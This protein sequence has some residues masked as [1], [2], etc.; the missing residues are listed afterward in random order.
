VT[1]NSSA[2]KIRVRSLLDERRIR[3]QYRR[4]APPGSLVFDVGANEGKH[5][6]L[7]ASMGCR[8]V[9]VEPNPDVA[10]LIHGDGIEV[11]HAAAG[12]ETGEATM[13]LSSEHVLGTL[14]RAFASEVESSLGLPTEREIVVPVTT[15]DELAARYGRPQFVKV[16]VEGYEAEAFAGMSVAPNAMTFE[17]HGALLDV[18]AASLERLSSLERYE[19]RITTGN[20]FKPVADWTTSTMSVMETATRLAAANPLLYAD[21]SCRR[22]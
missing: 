14:S 10:A 9:A 8:V 11:V 5:S 7:L 21:V 20:G 1:S 22:P 2:V 4:L 13:Y 3:R 17:F 19:Y 16:D 12:A 18:L 6:R 15:M